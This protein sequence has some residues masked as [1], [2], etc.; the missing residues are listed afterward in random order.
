MNAC[1]TCVTNLPTK[2]NTEELQ[3]RQEKDQNCTPLDFVQTNDISR[4]IQ[5]IV[6]KMPPQRK[7]IYQMSRSQGLKPAAIAD[8]LSLSV[9]TVKNVLSGALK[10]IRQ[11]LLQAGITV[12]LVLY[13]F[14]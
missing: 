3:H 8:Q 4:I 7:I 13:H 14:Y 6:N 9:G 1:G 12:A 5:S 11:G 10:E 2:K